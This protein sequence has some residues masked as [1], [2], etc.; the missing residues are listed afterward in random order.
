M[1]DIT[2][3]SFLA[4]LI[5]TIP[6]IAWSLAGHFTIGPLPVVYVHGNTRGRSRFKRL[7]GDCQS[8]GFTGFEMRPEH[9]PLAL[10]IPV[11]HRYNKAL[12]VCDNAIGELQFCICPQFRGDKAVRRL[13]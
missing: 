8:D 5:L 7:R 3:A 11:E 4:L 9:I 6:L 12:I 1:L 2:F 13:K 10:P